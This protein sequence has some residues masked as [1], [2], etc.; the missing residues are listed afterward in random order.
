MNE[1]GTPSGH[2][3]A[4]PQPS[5]ERQHQK[6]HNGKPALKRRRRAPTERRATAL[7]GYGSSL[8]QRNT[9]SA[10]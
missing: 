4:V 9:L 10:M 5:E 3:G 2:G 8:T 7:G 1:G 6:G